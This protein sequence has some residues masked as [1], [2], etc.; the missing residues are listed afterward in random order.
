MLA[1]ASGMPMIVNRQ[2]DGRHIKF[3]RKVELPSLY[4]MSP[5][6]FQ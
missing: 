3:A 1:V 2:G 6:S 5:L 4:F